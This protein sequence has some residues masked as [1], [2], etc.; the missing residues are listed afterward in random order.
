MTLSKDLQ[1]WREQLLAVLAEGDR[2]LADVALLERQNASL[3]QRLMEG[4]GS[5]F[6]ALTGLYD[7]GFHICPKLFGQAREGEECLFCLNFLLHKGKRDE[8]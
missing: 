2:L 7:E 3:Q 1:I 5:G 4:G 8:R 6:E